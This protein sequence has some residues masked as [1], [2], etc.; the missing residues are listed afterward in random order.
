[1]LV[2]TGCRRGEAQSAAQ[3]RAIATVDELMD[4]IVIPASQTIFD[5][6]VYSNGELVRSPKND[7]DWFRVRMSALAVAESGNLLMMP[8]RAEDAGEWA[9]FSRAM[10]DSAVKVAAAAEARDIEGILRTGGEMY[11]ACSGCHEKYLPDDA[12]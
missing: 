6:V 11:T 2:N 10:T 8:P 3:Y 1:M 9:T 12:Q 7:D 4:G 5:A